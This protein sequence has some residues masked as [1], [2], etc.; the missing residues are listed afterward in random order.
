[1]DRAL[2]ETPVKQVNSVVIEGDWKVAMTK[3]LPASKTA[4]E[5]TKTQALLLKLKVYANRS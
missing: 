4:E 2:F 1:M 5:N 3:P